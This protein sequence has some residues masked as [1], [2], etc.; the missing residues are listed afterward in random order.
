MS[1]P[2]GNTNAL[3]HG[4]YS[5]QFR[6]REIKDLDILLDAGSQANLIDEI[7]VLRV[8]IRRTLELSKGIDDIETAIKW[9]SVLGAS[10]TRI[11]TLLRTQRILGTDPNHDLDAITLA[12]EQVARD[13]SI[14]KVAE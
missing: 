3:K 7:A 6:E 9:L 14:D 4:F 5:R 2:V 1:A 12:L 10:S 11:A 13:W 8:T